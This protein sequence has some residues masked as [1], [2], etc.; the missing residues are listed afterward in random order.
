MKVEY[1][2]CAKGIGESPFYIA[3]VPHFSFK[4][5]KIPGGIK[6]SCTAHEIDAV[7]ETLTDSVVETVYIMW[8][9]PEEDDIFYREAEF[10]TWGWVGELC[11]RIEQLEKENAELK[12]RLT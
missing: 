2:I 10:P 5:E 8:K 9:L 3:E 4:E 12:K 1:K 11:D 6:K 7:N